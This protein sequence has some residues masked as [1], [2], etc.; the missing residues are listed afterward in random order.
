MHLGLADASLS[1]ESDEV[2]RG[3]CSAGYTTTRRTAAMLLRRCSPSLCRRA[4]LL[5]HVYARQTA[6]LNVCS[7]LH[8]HCW[9]LGFV[10]NRHV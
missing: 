4:P 5:V 8:M 2:C 3:P 1:A 7:E 6:T 9:A 10:A